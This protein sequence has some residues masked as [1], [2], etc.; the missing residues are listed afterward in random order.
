MFMKPERASEQFWVW[1]ADPWIAAPPVHTSS[2]SLE[3][4]TKEP[5]LCNQHEKAFNLSI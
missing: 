5:A 2:S 1:Q 4:G 3:K